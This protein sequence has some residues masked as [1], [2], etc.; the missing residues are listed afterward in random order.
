MSILIG[1][2]CPDGIIV[3]SDSQVTDPYQGTFSYTNKIST[4]SFNID[5]ILVAQ[6]GLSS[7][8]NRIVETMQAK[9]KG[10]KITNHQI[11]SKIVEDSIRESKQDLDEDQKKYVEQN[12]A[13]LMVAFYVNGTPYLHTVNVIG[14]GILEPSTKLFATA[15]IGSYLANYLLREFVEPKEGVELAIAT[16]IFVIKKVNDNTKFCG[17]ETNVKRMGLVPVY[18]WDTQYVGKVLDTPQKFVNLTEKKLMKEYENTKKSR[19][20]RVRAILQNVG[21]KVWAEHLKK[22]KAELKAEEEEENR[23]RAHA[24]IHN[25]VTVGVGESSS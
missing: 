22:V 2:I 21:A 14:S 5:E 24:A 25:P 3:A 19:N 20:K 16:S 10:I 8:T 7:I 23:N 15:G 9:S 17:G 4:V 1:I 6:A 18:N 12:G 11:V 13:E